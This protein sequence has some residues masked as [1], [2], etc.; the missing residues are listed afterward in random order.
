[1]LLIAGCGKVT[2]IAPTPPI[3]PTPTYFNT[4]IIVSVPYWTTGDVYLGQGSNE[5]L[6][7]LDKLNEVIFTKDTS[8]EAGAAYY[9]THFSTP[10]RSTTTFTA[11]S[12][13]YTFQA[14]YDWAD[15]TKT[16][17]KTNFMKGVTFGGMLWNDANRA[18][19][20]QNLPILDEFNVEWIILIPDWFVFGSATV[21]TKESTD[22][23]PFYPTDGTFPNATNWITPTLPTAEVVSI[24]RK[25][26]A[27]GKKV[28]L[29]PH[30]DPIDFGIT[31]GSGRGSLQPSAT[32]WDEWFSSYKV[33]LNHYADIA[34]AEGVEL[35]CV[36]CELDDV[37]YPTNGGVTADATAR[38]KDVVA[39][40]RAR[41]GGK[42]LYSASALGDGSG[43]SKVQFWDV[44]DY[45][46]FEPYFGLTTSNDPTVAEM[47]AAFDTKLDTLAK[48]LYQT[49]NKPIIFSEANCNSFSGVNKDPL[50]SP[51]TGAL[52]DHQEQADY[53]E[54]LFQSIE[55]RN[56]IEGVFWWAWYLN[57]TAKGYE[58]DWARDIYDPFVRKP[59]G[60][61]MRKW[62]GKIAD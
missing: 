61:V 56:W 55:S 26:K 45:I 17:T 6:L 18:L 57:S 53:Y 23:R 58:A 25:A 7:K 15:S 35:F 36:G 12:Y 3:P 11:E 47:K 52:A 8:L 44:L 40:V 16:I 32:K 51:P 24:I 31:A 62:Y 22:I 29:K 21:P 42:L 54:A 50:A 20:D 27:A 9:F 34:Q 5:A 14:V 33:F 38:W 10:A 49:Y 30:I 4:K 46:G 48:P 41:Y 37:T 59:A 60:Q 28:M 1:M 13:A 43:P 39:S 2:T 19:V